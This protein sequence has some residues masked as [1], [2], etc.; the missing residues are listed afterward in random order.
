MN[1]LWH[2]SLF[3]FS[4]CYCPPDHEQFPHA[5]FIQFVSCM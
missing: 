2:N 3:T 1:N 5:P 4:L